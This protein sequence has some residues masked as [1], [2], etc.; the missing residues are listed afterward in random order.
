[1]AFNIASEQN[2]L[3]WTNEIIEQTNEI[4][5]R[6]TEGKKETNER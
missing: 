1:M 5:E 4:E 6:I 3:D 2:V